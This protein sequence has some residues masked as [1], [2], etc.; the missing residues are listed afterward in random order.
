ME[1]ATNPESPSYLLAKLARGEQIYQHEV[2]D[3][4]RFNPEAF[5]ELHALLLDALEGKLKAKPGPKDSRSRWDWQCIQAAVEF[6]AADISEDRSNPFFVRT[7]DM[8][9]P[10]EQAY[11]DVARQF[12]LAGGRTLQNSLSSRGLL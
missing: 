4:V 11:E 5:G 7:R 9:S 6:R 1:E 10:K 3:V 8:R 2:I 12:K